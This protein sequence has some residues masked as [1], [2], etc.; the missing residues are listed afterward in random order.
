MRVCVY[1]ACLNNKI[2]NNL[3][4]HNIILLSQLKN[5][6]TF[7]VRLHNIVKKLKYF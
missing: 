1:G 5:R 6:F 3:S 7:I 2:D 4:H